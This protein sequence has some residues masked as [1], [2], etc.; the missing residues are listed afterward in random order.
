M[1]E[2]EAEVEAVAE[3]ACAQSP[4]P[5]R[6]TV[7]QF[8]RSVGPRSAEA[9]TSSRCKLDTLRL[10]QETTNMREK[11]NFAS[12]TT[13][14]HKDAYTAILSTQALPVAESNQSSRA[15]AERGATI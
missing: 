3:A 14:K 1:A 11:G 10:K 2:A 8:G 4:S 13:Y 12:A 9:G 6:V 5:S 15:A 7:W